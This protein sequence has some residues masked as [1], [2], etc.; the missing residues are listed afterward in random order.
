MPISTT[1]GGGGATHVA[2]VTSDLASNVRE[3]VVNLDYY[4]YSG[5]YENTAKEVMID[6]LLLRFVAFCR[7]GGGEFQPRVYAQVDAGSFYTFA[8]GTFS[9]T[10]TN[11]PHGNVRV[12]YV[13]GEQDG[14][15]A[16]VSGINFTNL[17]NTYMSERGCRFVVGGYTYNLHIYSVR[18]PNP[19]AWNMT[20]ADAKALPP[21]TALVYF[22]LEK[23]KI[24]TV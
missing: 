9:D 16:R 11:E 12:T 20:E 1:G 6:G 3:G 18:E 14:R 17:E 13:N 21:H 5:T 23:R 8:E 22:K 4:W 19:N 2:D 7:P 10:T 24:Y 15:W